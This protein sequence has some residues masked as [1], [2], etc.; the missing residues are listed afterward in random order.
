MTGRIGLGEVTG[1]SGDD[2]FAEKDDGERTVIRPNP[3]GRR[4]TAAPAPQAA[5]PFAD[6]GDQQRPQGGGD[7]YGVPQR[8]GAAKPSADQG[9][10]MTGMN[11]LTACASPLFALISRIRNRAQHVDPDKLR[12]SVVAEVRAFES[13]ALSAQIEPQTVKVARYALCATLDDVVLNTPW[14]GQSNWA[15]QSMVGT[16]HRETVGGDRF[17]DLLARLEK[18]PGQNID[19]L[20]FLYTC[21]SL[22]FEGRLRVEDRGS[23]KHLQI[24]NSLARIIRGQRGAIEHDLS[25]HWKG[26]DK[27]H[28]RLSAWKPVWIA[29]GVTAMILAATYGGL[30]FALGQQ[31]GTLI[32]KISALST[33]TVAVLERRAPPP[34]PPPPTPEAKVVIDR[35]AGFLEDQ[36]KAGKVEVF[37]K[38]NTL[39]V[40]LIGTA[41]FKS[42]SDQVEG[43]VEDLI[44]Q[45]GEALKDQPGPLI[46]AG[47]SDSIPLSGRGRFKDNK[48]LSLARAQTV[49]K[50]LAETLGSSDRLTAEGRGE[51]DPIGDNATPEGR[52]KNRRIEI[53]LVK[54]EAS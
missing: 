26:L 35:T 44:A 19:L 28:R 3:G 53:F 39:V 48:A 52:A 15:L 12:Q 14:G 25:P 32:G 45:V 31:S 42:G 18:D 24:R 11:A 6:P 47:Y 1:M 49:A 38:G 27:P 33:E 20:E 43:G 51:K 37:E 29:V 50:L 8:A 13:R 10:A 30:R 7:A 36:V 16:F 5:S 23:D 54:Q 46:I 21:L 40:R 17:Y 4:G 41:L 9:I 2:P 34:P 22:G